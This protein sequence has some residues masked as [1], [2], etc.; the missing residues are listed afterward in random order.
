MSATELFDYYYQGLI[1]SLPMKNE[2]F[3]EELRKHGLLSK[4]TSTALEKLLTSVERASYFLDNVIKPEL[5]KNDFEGFNH[6]LN[7]MI[8]SKFP[9]A[10]ELSKNI[11]S[12][13][14]IHT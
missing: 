6:L 1:N 7:I 13:L 14:S 2:T 9:N 12:E 8:D 10:V 3:L 11:K 4:D 5:V